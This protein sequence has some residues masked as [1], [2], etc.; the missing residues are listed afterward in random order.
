MWKYL[1]HAESDGEKVFFYG[2][3]PSTL[4][5]LG[6][7]IVKEFPDLKIAGL[8]SPPYKNL[9]DEEKDLY[10]SRI[11]SSGAS[12]VFVGLGCPKQEKWMLEHRHKL[13]AVLV[14]VGAAFDYHAVSIFHDEKWL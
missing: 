12:V 8:V 3:M 7:K 4:D 11:N 13:N 6:K 2:G 1:R 14:G 9:N 5:L 10:I